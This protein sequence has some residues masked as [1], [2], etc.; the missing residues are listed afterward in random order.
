MNTPFSIRYILKTYLACLTVFSIFRLL[1]FFLNLHLLDNFKVDL[2]TVIQSF[3]M[4]VR[5]DIV[6]SGYFLILP[7][8]L[9]IIFDCS[10][11]IPHALLTG[12]RYW[13]LVFFTLH[14]LV[15]AAD[16]PYFMQFNERF[17]VSA[18]MWMNT[19][20]MVFSMILE[21]PLYLVAL[22][23]FGILSFGFIRTIKGIY[24][25][26]QSTKSPIKLPFKLVYS[27]LILT[28]IVAGIRGR[29]AH[30]SPIR[31][32]TAY[33]CEVPFL[34]K[35]GLNPSFT[36]LKS[37]L[38]SKK[39]NN[40]L[41]DLIN[42][43]D[44]KKV[45]Q[46]YLGVKETKYNSPIARNAVEDTTSSKHPNVVL[47]L[48]ES[49]SSAKVGL[50]GNTDHLTPFLDSLSTQSLF[51][52]NTYSAG[53]H[54][55]NGIFGTLFSYPSIY[56]RH[57]MKEIAKYHGLAQVLKA[58]N[59]STIYFSTH[60]GQYD[61]VEGFLRANDFDEVITDKD[62]PDEEI[63]TIYGVPD[64]YLFRYGVNKLNQLATKEKPFFA[65]FCT[66]SDHGP[67]Y[68]PKYFSP[69][70]KEIHKQATEYA[71]WSLRQLI[72]NS[73]KQKWFENTLFVFVADH[74][75]P[76]SPIYDLPLNYFHV[77]LLFYSPKLI[78]E[79]KT[80]A[81]LAS[82]IDVFPS[83][84]G[85]LNIPFVNNTMGIDLFHEDRKYAI[86]T[87]DDKFGVIDTNMVCVVRKDKTSLYK[88]MQKDLKDYAL[89]LPKKVEQMST[90][91][92]AHIQLHQDMLLKR[93]TSVQ[94]TS[95]T[96]P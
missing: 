56:R 1:L 57:T 48:M 17:S 84:M 78:K 15:S 31:I 67:Y 89:E 75:A 22:V 39:K 42:I 34:N 60:D 79:P 95:H 59:Y 9:L 83:I 10:G 6:I 47:I 21:E 62:Y 35:L 28:L 73:R 43:E 45:V 16:I 38:E 93:Q 65:T 29:L 69:H 5:F 71:D 27:L 86:L 66:V 64:D 55:F 61:N 90:F 88:H 11:K 13:I 94:V 87:A 4:G 19:P 68:I 46:K 24:K 50:Q 96:K 53:T 72:K 37:Y 85:L 41:V 49:M 40:R 70:S 81:K 25:P 74:G 20:G 77:P 80:Y 26:S 32:G 82:Q 58:E 2:T 12:I 92:K 18:F 7:A 23:P 33:Y 30:K 54:T 8:V 76:I 51:F 91:G 52:K 3:I 36:L 14:F 63:K 44:A